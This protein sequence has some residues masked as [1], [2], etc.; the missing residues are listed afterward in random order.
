MGVSDDEAARRATEH[1]FSRMEQAEQVAEV[2]SWEWSLVT[3]DVVWSDNLYR[4]HGLQPGE[5]TPTS[6]YL[7]AMTHP[8]DRERVGRLVGFLGQQGHVAPVDYRIVR[9]D[10]VT[11]RLRSTITSVQPGDGPPSSLGGVVEDVTDEVGA[12]HKIA[13]H[14]A[15]SDALEAWESLQS[16]ALRLLRD[17]GGALEFHSATLWVPAGDVLL[18]R[19]VWTDPLHDAADFES[20]TRKLR[21]RRGECLPGMVW[22]LGHAVNIVD[23]QEHSAYGRRAAAARAGLHAAMAVPASH[24]DK[25]MAVVELNSREAVQLDPRL[26]LSLRAIGSE[27]G[28]FLFHRRGELDH[29][30]LTARQ[31][32]VIELAAQGCSGGQIAERLCISATTVKSH[33]TG[34]YARLGVSDRA[35]AVAEAM[36][37]GLIK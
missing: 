36:R 26:M 14:I 19:A 1:R 2:G 9:A 34:I 6:A 16:G 37:Y 33:F 5:V 30:T 8:D 11:R 29:R 27:L 18:A 28:Q 32:Q 15:V 25:V 4:L 35:A 3:G 10:G 22:E 17:L 21:L 31:L 7:L 23:V 20:V 13:S 24:A 12:D